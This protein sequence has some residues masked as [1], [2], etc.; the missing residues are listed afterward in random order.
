[1]ST[2]VSNHSELLKDDRFSQYLVEEFVKVKEKNPNASLE[3]FIPIARK[4]YL[5]SN[6]HSDF[7]L[8]MMANTKKLKP[9]NTGSG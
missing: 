5:S 8:D 6:M 9:N 4:T 1:M 3:K 7:S 2:P